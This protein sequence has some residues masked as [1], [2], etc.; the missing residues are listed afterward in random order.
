MARKNN[1]ILIYSGIAVVVLILLLVI[2]KKAG[3]FGSNNLVEVAVEKVQAR[4]ITETVSASGKIQPELE[5]KIS[6]DVSGE[7][8]ALYVKEGDKVKKGQLL[9]KI[10]PD[11]YES[12]LDRANASLNNS[13]ANLANSE[14]RFIQA[15]QAYNR[16][17]KLHK[18]KVISDADFE[19]IKS[20]YM[21]AKADVEAARYNI[22]SAEASVKEAKDNLFKTTIF[23]PVDGTVSKLNVELGERVVGTTQMS[24]TEMMR[25]ANLSNMEVS[26]DVNENDINRL[27]LGDTAKIEV[28]AFLGKEFKGIVTEIAN[29]ANVVGTNADQVTNFTVKIRILS[30]SYANLNMGDSDLPS[31]FR[32]GLSATVEILTNRKSKILTVPIQSVSVR[33]DTS[34]STTTSARKKKVEK[35]ESAKADEKNVENAKESFEVVFVHADGKVQMRVVKTGIQDDKYIEILEG[36][37]EG[38]EVVTAP[39]LAISKLLKNGTAVKLMKESELF[40]KKD[41]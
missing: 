38:D 28:D 34:S 36:L 12:Y 18:E 31:P 9:V 29:S 24:G 32:P 10:R 26:V 11:V 7:I 1:K 16:N 14:A 35:E 2:G 37:K 17:V 23:S 3:W 27:G 40:E 21:V 13:K 15:E 25:I 4:D 39:Y 8:I 19:Q 5:V 33:E 30:E 20:T 22:K 6:P 41:K